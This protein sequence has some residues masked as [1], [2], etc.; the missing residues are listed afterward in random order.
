MDGIATSS[1]KPPTGLRH[2][3]SMDNIS[4]GS[5]PRKNNWPSVNEV[6]SSY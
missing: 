1:Y 2:A 4:W 5:N 3:Q 6:R